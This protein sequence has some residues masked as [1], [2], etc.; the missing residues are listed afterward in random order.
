[1]KKLL[2]IATF[3]TLLTSCIVTSNY[4]QIYKANPSENLVKK[5][6]ILV[7]EDENCVVSY[8]LKTE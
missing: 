7:F 1:M 4:Y 8:N 3:V 5:G 2:F 6:N